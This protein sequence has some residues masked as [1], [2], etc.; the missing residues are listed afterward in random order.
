MRDVYDFAKYFIKKGADSKPNTYDG[1]M[2][3]QKLL[4]LAYVVCLALYDERL[5]DDKILAFKNGCVVEKVRLRYK[6]DYQ[7]FRRDSDMFQPAFTEQEYNVLNLTSNIFGDLS[8]MELSELNH[9]FRFWSD[10]YHNG[11]ADGGYHDKEKSV[12]DFSDYSDDIQTML[13][14]I[15][16]HKEASTAHEPME[17]INGVKFFY[18]GISLTDDIVDKLAEFAKTATDNAYSVYVENGE[19]V[20]Y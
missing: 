8:A 13:D 4:V 10:A 20:V 19:L 18:E 9:T 3:L 11:I 1:N 16:A 7:G 12:V 14:I 15:N 17:V 2:K 6:N 5:F